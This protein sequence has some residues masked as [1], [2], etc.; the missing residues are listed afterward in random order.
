[1]AIYLNLTDEHVVAEFHDKT[2]PGAKRRA[3]SWT[4]EKNGADGSS[5]LS[6]PVA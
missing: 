3:P 4:S 5:D 2:G 1:M 6:R